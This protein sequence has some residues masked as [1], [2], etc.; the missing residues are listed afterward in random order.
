[1]FAH[2]TASHDFGTFFRALLG[3]A[4]PV[5]D[6]VYACFLLIVLSVFG[7]AAGELGHSVLH[8]PVW[9]G[10]VLLV[11]CI[12]AVVTYGNHSVEALFRYVTYFLYAIYAALFILCLFKFPDPIARAFQSS[13]PAGNWWLGGMTYAGYNAIGAVAILP[14]LRHLQSRRDAVVAGVLAGVLGMLPALLFFVCMS[15][16]YPEIAAATLPSDYLLQRLNAPVFHIL[17]QCMI[18][19]ALLESGAGIVHGANERIAAVLSSRG[20]VLSRGHRLLI[21]S[22]LLVVSVWIAAQFGLIALVA[23]GYRLLA[24]MML[25]AYVVPIFTV[26]LWRATR[27][28]QPSSALA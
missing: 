7:A 1:L 4:A 18:F 8:W 27:K 24:L 10:T 6:V 15:A 21:G 14:V 2:V 17:F 3:R 19:A 16:F 28:P 5:F 11:L 13:P 26:G 22:V 23:R 20:A 12:A 9:T 25:F